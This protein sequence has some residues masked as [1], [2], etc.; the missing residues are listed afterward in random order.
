[1]NK[2]IKI[3]DVTKY[4]KMSTDVNLQKEFFARMPN[5]YDTHE[6]FI[7]YS[8]TTKNIFITNELKTQFMD[9]FCKYQQ[10][11]H[12]LNKFV[13]LYK[14][15]KSPIT[16]KYDLTLA[17]I[18]ENDT[19]IICIFQNN[20]RYLFFIKDLIKIIHNSLSKTFDLFVEPM[21]CKNPYNNVLFNKSTLYNIYFYI[22]DHTKLMPELFFK[23]FS[24]HF[25]IFEFKL[26]YSY[27][28]RDNAIKDYIKNGSEEQLHEDI[29]DM[30]YEFNRENKRRKIVIHDDFPKNDLNAIMK[31]YLFYYLHSKYSLIKNV[32]EDSELTLYLKLVSFSIY[33]PLFGRKKIKFN[34][35]IKN[36]KYAL[37]SYVEFNKK[38]MRF[39]TEYDFMSSHIC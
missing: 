38:H 2:F 17:P 26:R 31:P 23:Y 22:K 9:I 18:V 25:N 6:K 15:K 1:M 30:I 34:Y 5:L 21:T 4:L 33:N 14:Y 16:V 39:K 32:K 10:V 3:E 28:L 27:L 24:V 35:V 19:N 11:Y 37:E 8:I 12:A 36:G 13:Y 29:I 7:F 20:H